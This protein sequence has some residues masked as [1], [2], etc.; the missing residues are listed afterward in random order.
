MLDWFNIVL[1]S[2]SMSV[3]AMTVSAVDSIQEKNMK[4]TKSILIAL[5]FGLFQFIMPLIGYFIG[6]SFKDILEAYIP[7]IAF[8]LLTLLSIKSL[9]DWIKDRKK[10]D[11]GEEVNKKISI[12]EIL[13]QGISTSIDALC[14][15]F[16][17][18]NLNISNAM[19]VFS[20]IGI[21]TFLLS[22]L[23]SLFGNLLANKLEKWSGLIAAIVFLAV[24]LKILIEG[25]IG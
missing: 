6:Y 15:G 24:G 23:T 17:Y 16:V 2:L 10:K 18:L 12:L 14:I 22:L 7:W 13:V 9:I 21:T 4:K 5:V 8:S 19:I 3:D 20:I 1:T 25:L 11:D